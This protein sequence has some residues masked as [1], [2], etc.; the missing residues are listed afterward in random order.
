MSCR[1][2]GTDKRHIRETLV[3]VLAEVCAQAKDPAQCEAHIKEAVAK[4]EKIR[5][6]CKGKA[7]EEYRACVREQRGKT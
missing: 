3:P 7:G 2:A 4:R 6:A 5:E 1:L